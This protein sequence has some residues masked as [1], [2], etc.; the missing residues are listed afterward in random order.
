MVK[1]SRSRLLI[2]TIWASLSRAISSSDSS[3]H[4]DQGVEPELPAIS[5]QRSQSSLP[6]D[7]DNQE[8]R[9]RPRRSGFEHLDLIQDEILAQDRQRTVIG[10]GTQILHRATEEW[11][12]RQDGDGC[13]AMLLVERGPMGRIQIL[14]DAPGGRGTPLQLGNDGHSGTPER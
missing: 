4:F 11:A 5:Q 2:P 6:Q 9:R 8:D 12:V 1:V 3:M 7:P 14:T 13:G 10:G